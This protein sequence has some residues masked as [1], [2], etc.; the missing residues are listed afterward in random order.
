[1][2]P[3]YKLMLSNLAIHIKS[4]T[5]VEKATNPREL[6][7]MID[8]LGIMMAKDSRKIMEDYLIVSQTITINDD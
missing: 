5:A 4:K 6:F 8:H 2:N 3:L 7:T 1:M